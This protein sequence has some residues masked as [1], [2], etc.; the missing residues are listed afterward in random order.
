MR[1]ADWRARISC[2]FQDFGRYRTVLGESVDLGEPDALQG[3]A[4]IR[5]ALATTDTTGFVD[6]LPHREDTMPGREF[7]GAD[8][9]EGQ[10]QELALARAR[11]RDLPLLLVL[12]EPAAS[13]DTPSQLAVF[14]H[15]MERARTTGERDGPITVILS[16]RRAQGLTR[17]LPRRPSHCRPPPSACS[18]ASRTRNPGRR[19][20]GVPQGLRSRF[21][22]GADGRVSA[23]G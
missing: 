1:T 4:R 23:A 14:E 3:A 21:S 12:D 5:K 8:L 13:P 18:V 9:S 10:W 15:H 17:S 6:R 22:G 19:A 11:M 16:H 20:A 2:A 7:G